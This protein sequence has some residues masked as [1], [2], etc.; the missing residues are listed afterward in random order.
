[1]EPKVKARMQAGKA[2]T[3]RIAEGRRLSVIDANACSTEARTRGN[4]SASNLPFEPR[5][6]QLTAD[7]LSLLAVLNARLTGQVRL[8]SEQA[9]CEDDRLDNQAALLWMQTSLDDIA[10]TLE[11]I[12]RAT[13]ERSTTMAR[14]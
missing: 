7:I 8:C 6:K 14:S 3:A 12:S 11:G 13:Q 9:G 1:M 10:A 4:D 5:H 2:K